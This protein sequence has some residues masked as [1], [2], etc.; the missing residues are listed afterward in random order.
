MVS[1]YEAQLSE[2]KVDSDRLD[3]DSD[4]SVALNSSN[5]VAE[6]IKSYKLALSS[7]S[8]KWVEVLIDFP[9]VQG[10]YT[11]SLP[12]DLLTQPGDIV[13]VPFGM[14][15][16]GGIVIQLLDTP[17]VNLEVERI[18]PI[19]DIVSSGFFPERYWE[20]LQRVAEYYLTDL[21][22]AIR[23]ALPPGLLGRTQ[24]RIRLV[25]DNIPQGA[26]TFCSSTARQIL[27]L[28]QRQK[29][30]NYSVKYLR[31]QE[32]GADRGIRELTKRGWVESY[33]EP[34][35]RIQAKLQTA[36][37]L[38]T[39]TFLDDLTSRQKEVLQVLRQNGGEMW[40]QE[41]INLSRTSTATLKK[42]AE[43]GYITFSEKE[44]LRKEQGIAQT[45]D[46]PKELSPAQA[47][48]LKGN[49]QKKSSS[50]G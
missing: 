8:T 43:R 33:L 20:L 27:Q 34:P 2:S 42:I 17:P 11:Y 15:K 46:I 3:R 13:S 35:K 24:R 48:A 1:L 28:L 21:M 49:L 4:L 45:R 9:G 25:P 18:R 30:G 10:L 22:S 16:T 39:E 41:L 14:Q 12:H 38:V 36:V 5:L 7:S 23:V 29:D 32:K 50:L 47:E 44:I 31:N 40:Q 26:E 19:E 37:T 6:P